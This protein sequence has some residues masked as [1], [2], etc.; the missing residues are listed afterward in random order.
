MG[1]VKNLEKTKT[2]TKLTVVRFVKYSAQDL[3]YFSGHT[4]ELL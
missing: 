4:W 3:S 1:D 2:K